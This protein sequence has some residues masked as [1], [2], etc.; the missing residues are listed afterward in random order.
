MPSHKS[1]KTTK[2]VSV[3]KTTQIVTVKTTKRVS[4]KTTKRLSD[5]KVV[6]DIEPPKKRVYV[7]QIEYRV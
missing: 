1:Q 3:V 2:T 7:R 6:Y 5:K 4:D